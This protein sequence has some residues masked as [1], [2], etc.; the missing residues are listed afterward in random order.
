MP[1]TDRQFTR[2]Q[3]ELEELKKHYQR[4]LIEERGR[5]W[6]DANRQMLDNSWEAMIDQGLVG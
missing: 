5:E 4:E 2:F 1:S 6:F 3:D